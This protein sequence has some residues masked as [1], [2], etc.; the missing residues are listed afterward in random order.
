MSSSGTLRRSARLVR[1]WL[2]ALRPPADGS[3][4]P[5]VDEVTERG[6]SRRDIEALVGMPIG[7]LDLYEHALR[8]RSLFRGVATDGTESNE[9]LEFLGDAVLGAVVA[10]I[11]YTRFADRAE[12]LLTR[13]RATIVN[14]KALA[15]Y[16]EAIG[17]GALILMSENMDSSEGRSN[18]TILADAF[19]AIVGAV[20]L[21]LGFSAARRFVCAVLDQCVS[22]E[23]AA[24]DKSN[25]KSR[26]LEYVQGLGLEQP[27]YE[28][29]SEEGPSHDRTFTVAAVVQGERL[30]E[31]VDRS[32]KGAEQKAAEAA[33]RTLRQRETAQA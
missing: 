1:S 10:E 20:Y 21:D 18:Q 27:V 23:E 33:L 12:G 2:G 25:H 22:L 31:G 28:M 24:A 19:E 29:L 8:H 9:R 7:D 17:L 4:P 30:G 16:A 3:P 5:V 6:V 11:M 15:G 32:K 14:G 13:T 26:L